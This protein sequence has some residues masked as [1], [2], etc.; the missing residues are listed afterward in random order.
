MPKQFRP[1]LRLWHAAAALAALCAIEA[2]ILTI[3]W[4]FVRDSLTRS[5]E[6]ATKSRV[7]I[8]ELDLTFFPFPGC[9]ADE[10]LFVRGEGTDQRLARARRLTFEASWISLLLFRKN[11]KRL[12]AEGLQLRL[13][14]EIPPPI[15]TGGE[16]D[17]PTVVDELL[18]D[19]TVLESEGKASEAPVSF[20]FPQLLLTQVSPRERI[21]FAFT[22]RVPN[23]AGTFRAKGS[24]G[25]WH[26]AERTRT[27]V[28]GTLSIRA[29][30]EGTLAAIALRGDS[31][32]ENF[33]VR[34]TRHPVRFTTTFDAVVNGFSAEVGIRRIDARFLRSRLVVSGSVRNAKNG[35]GKTASLDFASGGTRIEDL[36]TILTRANP[37]AL[38]GR[39]DLTAR[40]TLP[41]GEAAFLRRLGLNGQFEIRRATFGRARTQARVNELSSRARDEEVDEDE[42][43]RPDEV[44]ARLSGHVVVRKGVA[45]LSNILFAVPGATARG[46]GTYNVITKR[47]DLQGKVAMEASVSEASSGFKASS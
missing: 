30:A 10:V 36:L 26:S 2:T 11:L 34:Q 8:G 20:E 47:V 25:P 46:A 4:P 9:T 5:L 3:R 24:L 40:V 14:D 35:D 12:R 41:D 7:T 45:R 23:P 32:I 1:R 17:K 27:P 13:P 15:E 22:A 31:V 21:G 44:D 6:R 29:T 38:R 39:I 16:D 37:P 42:G 43:E 33:E 18:A 19:G 28:S